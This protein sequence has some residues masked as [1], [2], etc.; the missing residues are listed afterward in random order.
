MNRSVASL[1]LVLGLRAQASAGDTGAKPF[2]RGSHA[3]TLLARGQ[4][5]AN[6]TAGAQDSGKPKVRWARK[7]VPLKNIHALKMAARARARVQDVTDDDWADWTKPKSKAAPAQT[8]Q[9]KTSG[10]DAKHS[11][12]KPV[13]PASNKAAAH[14][15]ANKK[16]TVSGKVAAQDAAKKAS[17]TKKTTKAAADAPRAKTKGVAQAAAHKDSPP[18]KDAKPKPV[19]PAAVENPAA[20]APRSATRVV[21]QAAAKKDSSPGAQE[22]AAADA[23]RAEIE[24][25]RKEDN[26][27]PAAMLKNGRK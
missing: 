6:S 14:P 23:L 17:P 11:V 18:R 21:A 8:A 27:I 26:G 7:N 5:M 22:K 20:D 9:P 16:S 19:T 15:A 24:A 1:F 3:E 25:L 12:G 2:G 13:V 4:D 10:A